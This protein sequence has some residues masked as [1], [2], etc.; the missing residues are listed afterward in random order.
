MRASRASRRWMRA[1]L[2]TR[3]PIRR[4]DQEREGRIFAAA[5]SGPW[6]TVLNN[7]VPKTWASLAERPPLCGSILEPAGGI[8]RRIGEGLLTGHHFRKQPPGDRPERETVM[9]MAK[10]EP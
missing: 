9:G 1:S 5:A 7:L 4:I 10:R 8:G 6:Q 2:I 3:Q